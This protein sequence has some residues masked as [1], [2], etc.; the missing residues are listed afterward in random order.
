MWCGFPSWQETVS[1]VQA[2]YRKFEPKYDKVEGQRLLEQA[3]FPELFELLRRTNR[4][5]YNQE[6]ATQFTSRAAT[7]VYARFLD[8]VKALKPLQIVTTNVD[9]MLERNLATAV[10]VQLSDLERCLDLLPA[11]TSF[12][13]KLHGSVSAVES[14]VFATSDYEH[15]LDGPTYLGTL[16]AL[17]AQATVLFIGYS[18]RDKYVLDLFEAN[19]DAR[20][21]FGDGP[22]FLV[23]PSDSPPLPDSI[24][25]IRYLPEPFAD[26]RSAIT[27]VDIVRVTRETG[28]GW[29]APENNAPRAETAFESSYFLTDVTP[30][31]TWRS[32]QSL[33]LGREGSPLTPNAVVGQGFDNSELPQQT[34]PAK[35]DLIVGLVSFDYVYIPLS[36][37][38]RL[39]DLLGPVTFWNCVRGG[40]FRFIHFEQEPVMMFRSI[41]AVAGGDV[42]ML[43]IPTADGRPFTIDEQIRKQIRPVPGREAEAHELFDTLAAKVSAFDHTRFNIPSLTRGALLHPSVQRLLGISDAVLPNSLPRWVT[44]PVIRLAHT[45]MA[46]CACDS[47]RLAATKIGFGSEILIGA[48]FAVSAARDWT[49]SVSSYVLTGRFNGDL[50]AYAELN[51]SIWSAI[52]TFRDTQ[53]GTSLRHEILQELS[54]T[55]GGEFTASVNAGLRQ[56]IPSAVMDDARDQLSGL[57]FRGTNDGAVVPAVWINVRNTDTITSLWRAR[58]KRELEAHCKVFGIGPKALCPCGSGEKLRD[59]CAKALSAR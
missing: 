41:D 55:A 40:V 13:A 56:I 7:P 20:P 12:V 10:T 44:F 18:L 48:A 16:R 32:S 36:Y 29:F 58:S 53:A 37:S 28:P 15:L 38:S 22:H 14:T 49:D 30:P 46:G 25:L 43:H 34:S 45:I 33:V 1:R 31:G 54:T 9:E 3:K 39:H 8:I 59:C 24:K 11:G 2:S 50:G 27:A 26:H 35:H 23:S 51:P 47:F 57:L 5:R 4:Q 17:F 42:G 19:C 6:L 52:L 21:L